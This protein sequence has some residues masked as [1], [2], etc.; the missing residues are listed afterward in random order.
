[1]NNTIV[2][3]LRTWIQKQ[4]YQKT[5][6]PWLW[7]LIPF[8]LIFDAI[9]RL[10]RLAYQKKILKSHSFQSE[11]STENLANKNQIPIIVVGNITVGGTGK[12]PLVI[13]IAKLLKQHSLRVG[14]VSRGYFGN[15]SS[16][17]VEEVYANSDPLLVGDEAVLLAKRVFCP[18]V[19]ANDRVKAVKRLLEVHA[20]DVIISDDGLQHYPLKRDIEIAV[21]DG[22]KRLGNGWTLPAG[23][24]REPKSRL[25]T[26][27]H[28]V[29]NCPLSF[30]NDVEYDMELR[31]RTVYNGKD[32]GQQQT[33]T[34]FQQQK[35]HALAG[36]GFPDRFF[37]LLKNYGLDII[38]HPFPD[39]YRFQAKDIQFNDG[40]PVIMTEKD[41]VKCG[42]FMTEHHWV[43][44]VDAAVNPLFDMRL[45]TRLQELR[46]G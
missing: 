38:A 31:P 32:P 37:D 41:A 25:V 44:A 35:I 39:H 17:A 33:L 27:D 29:V 19:V 26:V 36:I 30:D 8:A 23:P 40:L 10:R 1:M 46:R 34:A 9:V 15:K 22:K 45:L 11:H 3:R 14:I 20:V 12:T 28:V 43:L 5:L 6:S 4:W 2:N 24:L 7:V 18:I 42:G 21:V 16:D 13:H